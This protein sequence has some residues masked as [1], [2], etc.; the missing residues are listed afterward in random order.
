MKIKIEIELD[1]S[2]RDARILRAITT[3]ML[4]LPPEGLEIYPSGDVPATE[5]IAEPTKVQV[6]TKKDKMAEAVKE[7]AI[8]KAAE[9]VEKA[10]G[11]TEQPAIMEPPATAEPTTAGPPT[12]EEKSAA[13]AKLRQ[14]VLE[15]GSLPN[16]SF[17]E[18]RAMALK[19]AGKTDV[20]LFTYEDIVTA[21]NAMNAF[22]ASKI[23]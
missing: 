11:P 21:T 14:L 16:M 17:P 15:V 12:D 23:A 1:G 4:N 19:A 20:K 8:K 10:I 22:I 3:A 7:V 9:I 13:M 6:W 5:E 2:N 18:S